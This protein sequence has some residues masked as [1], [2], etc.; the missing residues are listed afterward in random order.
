MKASRLIEAVKK[1]RLER[2]TTKELALAF[3][4]NQISTESL[5]EHILSRGLIE[6]EV[7]KEMFEALLE[8]EMNHEPE[9][10]QETQ[11]ES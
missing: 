5:S 6:D 10:S 7:E 4:R 2:E 1:Y 9:S 11:K 3:E 8:L